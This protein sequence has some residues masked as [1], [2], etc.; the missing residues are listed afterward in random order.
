VIPNVELASLVAAEWDYQTDQR[1]GI[2]P[3][4][5]PITQL[6]FTAI[7]QIAIDPETTRKVCMS[8]LPTGSK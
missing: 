4:T 5:M 1:K 3:V 7:D 2:E 8:Y 6:F